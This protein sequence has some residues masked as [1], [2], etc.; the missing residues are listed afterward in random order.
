MRR[1]PDQVDQ[2]LAVGDALRDAQENLDATQLREFTKQR[3]QLT[4]SVTTRPP[5]GPGGGREDHAVGRRPGRGDADRGDARARR[6]RAVRSGLLVTSLA[7]TGLGDL[8]LSGAVALPEAL[9]FRRPPA[10]SRRPTR[11][12]G[13]SSTSYPTRM[14][15]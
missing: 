12:S 6:R 2:V 3:R 10:P 13:P 1:D 4:A 11:P 14:R 15:T 9:G 7:A 8:D 5:V